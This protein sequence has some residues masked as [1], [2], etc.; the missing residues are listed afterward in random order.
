MK[1]LL[2]HTHGPLRLALLGGLLVAVLGAPA[3]AGDNDPIGDLPKADDGSGGSQDDQ[4]GEPT[5][6]EDLQGANEAVLGQGA[7]LLGADRMRSGAL[8][9]KI[10]GGTQI[11]GPALDQPFTATIPPVL[12]STLLLPG[13]ITTG[14]AFLVIDH[15][16]SASLGGLLA[17]GVALDAVQRT[18]LAP[19]LD[20]DH[21]AALAGAYLPAG[22]HVSWVVFSVDSLG[23]VHR[24][25]AR[26]S[27]D[28]GATEVLID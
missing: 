13:D 14:Q 10:G 7:D 8:E 5:G 1:P 19:A 20:L 3:L 11:A 9:A 27:S 21:F 18:P 12:D 24:T 28:G 6:P 26:V 2:H 17:G 25:T 15:D 22:Y 23:T 4:I 16:S